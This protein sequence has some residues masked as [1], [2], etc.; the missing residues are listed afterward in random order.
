MPLWK[1]ALPARTTSFRAAAA[2]L[3]AAV[4][5]GDPVRFSLRGTVLDDVTV[6]AIAPW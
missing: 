4:R 5:V 2:G 3:A 1:V 6:V